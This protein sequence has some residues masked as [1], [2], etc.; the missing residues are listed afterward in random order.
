MRDAAAGRPIILRTEDSKGDYLDIWHYIAY[1]NP[2]AA[3]QMLRSIDG[4][5]ELYA[6]QPKMGTNRSRLG[7]GLR[8]FPVG[9]YL[10]FYRE[11]E[12]GIELIRVLHGARKL[13][14]KMFKG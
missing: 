10:V 3:D 9:N 6:S 11:I 2:D 8:S 7:R 14:K 13:R 1:D 4:K 5:L 12:G